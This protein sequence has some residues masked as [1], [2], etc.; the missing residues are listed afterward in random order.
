[1]LALHNTS[2]YD[3]LTKQRHKCTG[4]TAHVV[5]S[6]SVELELLWCTFIKPSGLRITDTWAQNTEI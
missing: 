2:T 1:M 4:I 5:I 6:I 3:Q